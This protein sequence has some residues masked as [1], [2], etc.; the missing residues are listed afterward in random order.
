MAEAVDFLFGVPLG[1]IV[2]AF[3]PVAHAGQCAENITLLDRAIG[4]RKILHPSLRA[5]IA[6]KGRGEKGGH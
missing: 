3:H 2:G 6:A 1:E 4:C 5:E